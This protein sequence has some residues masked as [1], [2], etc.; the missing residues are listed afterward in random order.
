MLND[1]EI[2]RILKKDLVKQ[3][4]D[5]KRKDIDRAAF[6]Y[7][8]KNSKAKNQSK[9]RK[10]L[11]SK[12]RFFELI[13]QKKQMMQFE[14][15]QVKTYNHKFEVEDDDSNMNYNEDD[16][17]DDID[18]ESLKMKVNYEAEGTN[19]NSQ[20]KSTKVQGGLGGNSQKSV[21]GYMTQRIARKSK[22]N[23]K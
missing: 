23:M 19:M 14:D 9:T 15:D 4:Q 20:G 8:I 21:P 12:R 18:P 10:T 5:L 22:S 17:K 3:L 1:D 16:L 7:E 6:F 13:A 2:E 11:A